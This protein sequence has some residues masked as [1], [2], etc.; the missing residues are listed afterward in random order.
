MN[1]LKLFSFLLLALLFIHSWKEDPEEPIEAEQDT[2]GDVT[3]LYNL[4]KKA[5]RVYMDALEKA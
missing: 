2:I 5:A 3:E 4:H 1:P